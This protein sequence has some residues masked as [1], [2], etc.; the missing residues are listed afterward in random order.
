[1]RFGEIGLE[2]ERAAYVRRG[3]HHLAGV[4]VNA[5]QGEVALPGRVVELERGV[6]RLLRLRV[7]LQLPARL[8]ERDER[9]DRVGVYLDGARERRLCLIPA[10][11]LHVR[12]G[13]EHL[14]LE[15]VR[16]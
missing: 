2:L 4:E 5:C 9:G 11:R 12:G 7:F 6:E 14:R 10:P 1:M 15:E 16:I 3:L 8:A 13:E